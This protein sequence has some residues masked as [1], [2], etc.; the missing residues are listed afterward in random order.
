MAVESHTSK[1]MPDSGPSCISWATLHVYQ[2]GSTLLHTL[3]VSGS[4]TPLTVAPKVKWRVGL[5]TTLPFVVP[6][7]RTPTDVA[8]SGRAKYAV[9]LSRNGCTAVVVPLL[10]LHSR[11]CIDPLSSVQPWHRPFQSGGPSSALKLEA[12]GNTGSGLEVATA[13]YVVSSPVVQ[14]MSAVQPGGGGDVGEAAAGPHR[15]RSSRRVHRAGASL[16]GLLPAPRLH[17]R[18]GRRVPPPPAATPH[19]A[20]CPSQPSA[21]LRCLC[22]R[23]GLPELLSQGRPR[24]QGSSDLGRVTA[25]RRATRVLAAITSC[26][27]WPIAVASA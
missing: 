16:A 9:T 17:S 27:M 22:C 14:F 13:A 26:H 25:P 18:R 19:P 2:N 5:V 7:M 21:I 10:P 3:V 15:S 11:A 6:A 20:G 8:Y 1:V 23:H 12:E 24:M 4:H